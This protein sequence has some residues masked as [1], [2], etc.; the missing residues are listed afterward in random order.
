MGIAILGQEKTMQ[1]PQ[2]AKKQIAEY[3]RN[4]L[5]KDEMAN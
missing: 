5:P 4:Q 1:I 2:D 3:I